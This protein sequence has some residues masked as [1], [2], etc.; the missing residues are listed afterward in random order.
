MAHSY[1]FALIRLSSGDNRDERLNVGLAVFLENGLDIRVASKLDK[2]RALSAALDPNEVKTLIQGMSDLD[3]R[4]LDAGVRETTRRREILGKGSPASFS[5]FGE[6]FAADQSAYEDRI[7]SII[8]D[9]VE[10]EPAPKIFRAK[11]SR[12]L[13]QVKQK[14]KTDRVLAIKGEGLSS[15][16]VVPNL[17]LG[18]GLIARRGRL[19]RGL[20]RRGRRSGID[21]SAWR[22]DANL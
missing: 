10:P 12:L 6:F 14:L 17:E 15:H 13:T 22:H 18:S 5:S 4:M 7:S 21:H 20:W 19:Q 3:Q 8:R 2:V 9:L 11:R 1:K 16:R